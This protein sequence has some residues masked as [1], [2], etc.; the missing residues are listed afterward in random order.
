MKHRFGFVLVMLCAL[1]LSAC[2]GGGKAVSTIPE[3]WTTDTVAGLVEFAYPEDFTAD[4]EFFNW[5]NIH[6]SDNLLNYVSG[7]TDPRADTFA[8]AEGAFSA[9]AFKSGIETGH[10]EQ[11]EIQ[12]H[13]ARVIELTVAEFNLPGRLWL[14]Q[15]D[16]DTIV[17][18]AAFFEESRKA[19]LDKVEKSIKII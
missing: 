18:I 19:D 3:G 11:T 13:K 10:V 5:T 12:G 15:I 7:N 4:G 1:V 8:L 6:A 17:S 14:I 2:S 16:D 9:G